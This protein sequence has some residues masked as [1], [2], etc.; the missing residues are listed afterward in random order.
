MCIRDRQMP[1]DVTN[2]IYDDVVPAGGH[3]R[4]P[5]N[6]SSSHSGTTGSGSESSS[7]SR[8][9][10]R[11]NSLSGS[12]TRLASPPIGATPTG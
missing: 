7:S 8:C 2:P 5:S 6:A 3:Q 4:L 1:S 11:P 9:H 12:L 10:S